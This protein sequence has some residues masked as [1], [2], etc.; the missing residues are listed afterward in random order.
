MNFVIGLSIFPLSIILLFDFGAVPTVW[1]CL[2]FLWLVWYEKEHTHS[3]RSRLY[4]WVSDTSYSSY[5]FLQQPLEP[6]A[7]PSWISCWQSSQ[8]QTPVQNLNNFTYLSLT[9]LLCVLQ[10][11][12]K[13]NHNVNMQH[14]YA[15][16]TC[17]HYFLIMQQVSISRTTCTK[18]RNSVKRHLTFKSIMIQ[19]KVTLI[20]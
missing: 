2:L 11:V 12:E 19:C 7:V 17:A 16:L 14:F 1:Y 10:C 5:I 8:D 6:L 9:V 20:V 3:A 18:S 13:N 4:F 15:I